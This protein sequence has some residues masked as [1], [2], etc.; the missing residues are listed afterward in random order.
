MSQFAQIL[1][2]PVKKKSKKR[3]FIVISI[4][5]AVLLLSMGVAAYL[6]KGFGTFDTSSSDPSSEQYQGE[7]TKDQALS[8]EAYT[9]INDGQ[10]DAAARSY[11][12]AVADASNDDEK[13]SILLAKS[14]AFGD[15]GHFQEGLDAALEVERLYGNTQ[16][17][18]PAI[19]E[20]AKRYEQLG[21]TAQA[22]VYT[23]KVLASIPTDS[24]DYQYQKT[25]Y[26]K[27]LEMLEAK[28]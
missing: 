15:T 26:E 2:E 9:Q 10:L 23:K 16:Y 28:Q 12:T 3:L 19:K 25:N 22:I 24:Y 4:I 11:D 8:T 20:I 5:I 6:T 7:I 27:Q 17:K 13:A 21:N 18:L 14:I 1:D